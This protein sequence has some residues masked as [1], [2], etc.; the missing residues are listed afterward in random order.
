MYSCQGS[1]T[2]FCLGFELLYFLLLNA[3]EVWGLSVDSKVV[4]LFVGI[5]SFKVE[6]WRFWWEF[7]RIEGFT[8]ELRP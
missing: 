4:L 5:R 2:I 8:F 7:L 1:S 3:L 6:C